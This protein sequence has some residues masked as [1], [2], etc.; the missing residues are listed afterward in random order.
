MERKKQEKNNLKIWGFQSKK[1]LIFILISLFIFCNNP[2]KTRDAEEPETSAITFIQPTSP[3]IVIANLITSLR[4]RNTTNY[5]KCFQMG[6]FSGFNFIPEPSAKENY[7]SALNEWDVNK[8]K[9][10]VTNLFF[11][12]PE[13]SL[14]N[15]YLEGIEEYIFSDSA[16]FIK[17]YTLQLHH[18]DASIPKDFSGRL[19]FGFTRLES[20]LWLISKWI[21]YRTTNQPV[22]SELKANFIY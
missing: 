11:S 4:E 1:I 6:D 14:S 18:T 7:I 3:D 13:D 20:G 9:T 19:E 10:Y 2:F 21:D 5:I 12:L 22:W 15:L 8:E 16:S 17:N